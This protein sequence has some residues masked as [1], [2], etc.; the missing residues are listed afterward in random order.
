MFGLIYQSNFP[1]IVIWLDWCLYQF[2]YILLIFWIA[3][4]AHYWFVNDF[5][6]FD[7]VSLAMFF[8]ACA[9]AVFCA[10]VQGYAVG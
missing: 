10:C 4:I 8:G 2:W 1:W 7:G 6:S 5:H 9:W 3:N